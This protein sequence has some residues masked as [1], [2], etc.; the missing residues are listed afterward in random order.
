MST[1][2]VRM[3]LGDGLFLASGR[4]GGVQY[5]LE[6]AAGV[7]AEFD[8]AVSSFD[9]LVADFIVGVPLRLSHGPWTGRLAV[10]HQSSH[11]GDDILTRDDVDLGVDGAVDFEAVE[12]YLGY[13][14]GPLRPYLGA[15][16]RFRRTPED[17][18]PSVLHAGVDIRS[19]GKGTLGLIGGAHG[20]AADQGVDAYGGSVRLGLELRRG[21]GA[22][23]VRFLLEGMVGSPD[24]GRFYSLRRGTYGFAIE[25]GR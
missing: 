20:W 18:D 16:Y 24:A 9:F 5:H 4:V 14:I 12:G 3:G 22:K 11:L 17:Q 2:L 25:V 6:L 10:Y 21:G 8:L 13:R 15:E 19:R 23:P 1:Q 7:Q